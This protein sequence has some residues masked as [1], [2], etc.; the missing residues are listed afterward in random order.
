MLI[1]KIRKRKN[2][3]KVGKTSHLF[4]QKV[5]NSGP[6]F[7][8][9]GREDFISHAEIPPH[10]S[11]LVFQD[12][13]QQGVANNVQFLIPQIKPIV[14]RNIAQKVHC[15]VTDTEIK[16]KPY[17]TITILHTHILLTCSKSLHLMDV[18]L[19]TIRKFT[20]AS[21]RKSSYHCSKSPLPLVHKEL[22]NL[23]C[24]REK[25]KM[26][27]ST[28]PSEQWWLF[29]LPRSSLIC[30]QNLC[31]WSSHPPTAQFSQFPEFHQEPIERKQ[32]LLL[33]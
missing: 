9:N 5:C 6:L 4:F 25:S 7:F 21:V 23:C 14:F 1:L 12:W 16:L 22:L 11:S 17:S 26:I 15:P 2:N 18:V 8:G 13:N 24:L 30:S 31:K 29:L 10:D 20:K 3:K 19:V 32:R 27:F 28:C 33:S